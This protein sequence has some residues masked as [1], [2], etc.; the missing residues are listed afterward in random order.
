MISWF[1]QL[2]E[3]L[4]GRR[5]VPQRLAIGDVDIR[6]RLFVPLAIA[7]GASYGFFMGW[8]GVVGREA[9]N[10]MQTIASIVKLPALFLLTLMVT[11]PSLYVFNALMGSRL[12]FGAT[13]RLL[14]GAVVVN[15]TVAAAFGP[16]LGFFT[17]STT[18]YSF[19]ILLNVLLLAI[20]GIVGLGFLLKVLRR[21]STYQAIRQAEERRASRPA[22]PPVIAGEPSGLSAM[23]QSSGAG[24]NAAAPI[25]APLEFEDEDASADASG[26]ANSIFRVWL[27]IY[28]L[29]GAQ[30]GWLLRPFIGSPDMEFTWFRARQGNFFQS[31][32]SHLQALLGGAG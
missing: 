14:V 30:M 4:R 15:L 18:S 13:L 22:P 20:A 3:L 5:T 32:Y 27:I 11:L 6:L 24:S 28:S 25:T 29:V 17:I 31:V 21:V 8:F 1:R 7:L 26:Q 10:Y 23:A 19:M 9:P 16:I 2:D 12:F